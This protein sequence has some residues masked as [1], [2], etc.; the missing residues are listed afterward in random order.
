VGTFGTYS[1]P[2][3]SRGTSA[4]CRCNLQSRKLSSPSPGWCSRDRKVL[5]PATAPW[6]VSSSC[7]CAF[8][9]T[10]RPCSQNLRLGPS[11]L[12]RYKPS[13][14]PLS[15]RTAFFVQELFST[16]QD[17]VPALARKIK[18][19]ELPSFQCLPQTPLRRLRLALPDSLY[20][21]P[22]ATRSRPPAH[23]SAGPC[24]RTHAVSVGRVQVWLTVFGGPSDSD[25]AVP[26][27]GYAP[28]SGAASWWP[29][30]RGPIAAAE[31]RSGKLVACSRH[32]AHL[33]F[34]RGTDCGP[35][36]QAAPG[37]PRQ[38]AGSDG[39][40]KTNENEIWL[41]TNPAVKRPLRGA[42]Y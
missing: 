10:Q 14:H 1:R 13:R 17:G 39:S 4:G 38:A 28:S 16:L 3:S 30:Q 32:S 8:N 20:H 23:R 27:S 31:R 35:A 15:L 34:P 6:R 5:V 18:N 21:R 29:S 33:R 42:S 26:V 22:P 12:I 24:S 36:K 19:R 11:N 7:S 40:S 2:K 9:L 25:R 41:P 37:G